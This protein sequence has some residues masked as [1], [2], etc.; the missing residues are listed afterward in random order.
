ML[1]KIHFHSTNFI[2]FIST[3]VQSFF[4]CFVAWVL[5]T[6]TKYYIRIFSGPNTKTKT[7]NIPHPLPDILCFRSHFLSVLHYEVL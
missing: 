3:I 7:S 4:K 1:S 2:I 6:K 5:R